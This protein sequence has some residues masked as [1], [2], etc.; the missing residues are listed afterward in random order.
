MIRYHKINGLYKRDERGKILPE[1][2]RPEFGYLEHQSWLWTEKVDGTNIRIGWNVEADSGCLDWG[3][4]CIGGRTDRS[5]IPTPLLQALHDHVFEARFERAF[6]EPDTPVVLFGEGY[7]PKIQKGG[8]RYRQ[9]PGF[10]LFDVWVAGTFLQREDVADVAR[11]MGIDVV[12]VR[13]IGSIPLAERMVRDGPL[14]SEWGAFE[15]EGLVGTPL[16]PLFTRTGERVI[17]KIKAKDY[18]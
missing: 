4:V 18:R 12:P 6:D 2:S 8:G 13:C 5:Q 1:Y 7:G 17:T 3:P 9:D 10:V 14:P 15:A 11:K 16:V